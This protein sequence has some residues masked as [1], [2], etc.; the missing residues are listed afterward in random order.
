MDDGT[1]EHE[2][3]PV[4]VAEVDGEPRPDPAEVDGVAWLTW[5]ALCGAGVRRS[6]RPQPLVGRADRPAGRPGPSPRSRC[7]TAGIAP[8]GLEPALSTA[9][10]ASGRCREAAAPGR[11]AGRSGRPRPRPRRAD[12][13]PDFLADRLAEVADLDP[14]AA[15]VGD[16]VRTCSARPAASGC[17]PRSPTGGTGRPAPPTT[18]GCW[19][20][21][22]RSSC[23][24][25]FALLHDD[26]MDRSATRRG[27]PTAHRSLA[28]L[29]RRDGLDGDDG[30]FGIS[31]AVL[32]GDLAFLW[33]TELLDAA[34]LPPGAVDPGPA[35][36][37]PAVHRGHRRPVPRPAAH[38]GADAAAS[39]TATRLA[40]R[41]AL[42]KSARYT[43]TR[44]LQLGAA[45]AEP[46]SRRPGVG[47]GARR[48]R[49]RGRPGV[50]APRR[51]AGPVRRARRSPAR[52]AST[53]SARASAPCWSCGRCAWR[54]TG[55]R[56]VSSSGRSAT[57]TSTRHAA[58]RCREIV[59]SS[60]ALAS[61]EALIA[62][63]QDEAV[64]GARRPGAAGPGRPRVAGGA[65][66]RPR[67]MTATHGRP[68]RSSWSGPASAACRRPATW[69]APG[70]DVTVVEA[71]RRPGRPGRHCSSAGGYRFD[72]GP[73]VLTMPAPRRALLPRRGRRDGT[74]CYASRPSTRCT[75]RCFA[76]GSELRVRHG[77]RRDDRGDPPGLRTGRRGRVRRLLRLARRASTRTEMP[78]F[79]ERN[80]DS[81]ARPGPPARPRARP[82]AARAPSAAWAGPWPGAS[83]TTACAASSASSRCTPAWRR[84]RHSRSTP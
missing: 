54:P 61:V 63:D 42:L 78:H 23:C 69:P 18:T 7:S 15:A 71:A 30:W 17:A 28:E 62:A 40:R 77:P 27:R 59:A 1:V 34:P 5:A 48:L 8:V 64:A 33:S 67:P 14:T 4:V 39:A 6:R 12:R 45:L 56:A 81:P 79:I 11:G 29:H 83:P 47:R 44:P 26:V 82:R 58:E 22:P 3:C 46:A 31:G 70:Y 66:R 72:T 37:R 50:P 55:D 52:A 25:R 68:R 49:R 74:T 9:R 16:E 2:L 53:T 80:Y 38:R 13:R 65:G 84:T 35:G 75:G 73:T 41:V 43:V 60:G 51:R 19:W 36:L 76:D 10:S 21:R 24:T 57:P 20:R 32:A